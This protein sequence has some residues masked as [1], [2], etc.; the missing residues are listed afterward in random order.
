M[1]KSESCLRQEKEEE[2]E[3]KEEAR[4]MRAQAECLLIEARSLEGK[5]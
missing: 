1:K 3:R 2:A 4:K 5:K